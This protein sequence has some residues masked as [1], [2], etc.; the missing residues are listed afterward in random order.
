MSNGEG[1]GQVIT[2]EQGPV[3]LGEDDLAN[4]VVALW[5]GH[6]LSDER[7]TWI[8][9]VREVKKFLYA[10]DTR[11][12]SNSV[13]ASSHSTHMPKLAQIADTLEA[14]YTSSWFPH[15]DWLQFIAGGIEDNNVRTRRLIESYIKSRHRLSDHESSFNTLGRDWIETGNTFA[16]TIWVSNT[17]SENMGLL[18]KAY[19]GPLTRRIDP[20]R[21]AFNTKASS[22]KE[23]WKVVQSVK[24]LGDVAADIQDEK[25]P[26]TYREVLQK[27][28]DFRTWARATP[29]EDYEDFLNSPF[30]GFGSQQDYWSYGEN[31]E[32]LTFYGTLY[33]SNTGILNRN[34]KIVVIDRKWILLEEDIGTWD[35]SPMIFHSAWRKRPGT[36]LGMGPCQNLTG[37]QYMI[38]HLQNTKADAF[39]EMVRPDKLISGIEDIKKRDGRNY[40]VDSYRRR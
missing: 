37:M 26:E 30:I 14:H 21:I 10:T 19:I 17:A 27:S 18:R 6:Y 2:L 25:L 29:Y 33:D 16:E 39:D 24:T 34:K 8:E 5:L 38:N 20:M 7:Q 22:F 11:S 12:T 36:L 15:S 9:E 13:N 23:S 1:T 4:K 35:G 31:V 40:M 3:G 28:L 32:F